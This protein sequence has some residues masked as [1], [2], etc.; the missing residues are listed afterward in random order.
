MHKQ[1]T[2]LDE[3]PLGDGPDGVVVVYHD[4]HAKP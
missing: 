2:L 1:L 3:E 4:G